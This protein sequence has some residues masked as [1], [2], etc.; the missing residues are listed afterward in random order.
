MIAPQ[1]GSSREGPKGGPNPR[2]WMWPGP[3][4]L[5]L[6]ATPPP[7]TPSVGGIDGDQYVVL[8]RK[9]DDMV[10]ANEIGLIGLGEVILGMIL[11]AVQ[12]P[13]EG[14]NTVGRG[15]IGVGVEVPAATGT[16]A[17]PHGFE[18]GG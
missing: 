9:V 13:G 12:E 14:T 4:D 17:P 18:P 11:L 15:G 16:V 3:T 6:W 7:P 1:D 10:Q 8:C 2:V 5:C